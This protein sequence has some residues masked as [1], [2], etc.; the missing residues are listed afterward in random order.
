VRQL[1]YDGSGVVVGVIS[2]GID[3]LAA[4]QAS[5]D[6]GVVTVP[7]DPRCRTR[8]GF[9]EGTAM[10]EIVHDLAPGAGLLFSGPGTSL[11]MVDA[12]NC[13]N[14]AGADVIVDDLVFFDQPFFEDGRVAQTAAAAVAS[15][16]SYHTAAG[17]YGDHQY[18]FETYRPGPDGFHDFDPNGS[19]ETLNLISIPPGD[20]LSCYLQWADPF[21]ASSNDYDLYAVD[22]SSH[23]IVS[24]SED[25]QDGS[26]DPS[27]TVQVVNLGLTSA[28]VGI[29]IRLSAGVARPLKLLCPKPGTPMQY[30]STQFGISG[31]AARPEVIAVA[32]I[33]AQ[34]PGLS[35]IENFSSRG[36]API[37]FPSP[38]TRPKPDIA[39]FDYV[40]TTVPGFAP[41]PGTSAAA[42]HSA[43]VAALLLSKNPNL[44]PAQVRSILTS[45]AVDI[46]PAGF[47]NAAGFGRID[48]LAAFNA[49]SAPLPTTSTT[50]MSTLPTATTSTTLPPCDP[51]DCDG[52]VCT[53]GDTCVAGECHPGS[54]LKAGQLS[55]LVSGRIQ[56]AETACGGDRRKVVRKVLQPLAH[57]EQLLG[58]AERVP[59]LKK[60]GIK[61]R[62]GRRAFGQAQQQLAKVRG[63]LSP[64]CVER[65][66]TATASTAAELSCLP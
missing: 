38:V 56:A 6:L 25:P 50:M 19:G 54:T 61:L 12:I 47:D 55:V 51:S 11:E 42:P 28:D 23:T 45:T 21:G 48:A 44:T 40:T 62:Q 29:A 16:V 46:G 14:A 53:V 60:F 34:D 52:N 64:S 24:R 59:T 26:Q 22:L 37:F 33:N 49:F 66:T 31:H 9:D 39:A 36:P 2:T 20:E 5:G 10:L 4:S 18:L 7:L 1:G 58:Q 8:S 57:T 17:N 30:A 41:F 35:D 3:S 63:K 65:L 27:E 32:A 13:L 43:A 15:G